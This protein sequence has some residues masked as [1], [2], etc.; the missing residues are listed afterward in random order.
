M[1]DDPTRTDLVQYPPAYPWLVSGNLSR[2]RAEISLSSAERASGPRSNTLDD[3]SDRT[4][5]HRL[6]L[7][8][9]HSGERSRGVVTVTRNRWR[10]AF[11]RRPDDLVRNRRIVV[12]LNRCKA[13]QCLVGPK[14]RSCSRRRLLVTR[15]SALPV[16]VLGGAVVFF[17]RANRRTRFLMAAAVALGTA[18][19][20]RPS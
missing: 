5:S 6:R 4:R 17:G 20:T 15:Q 1:I 14:C 18:L 12:A 16:F 8:H 13:Q 3:L 19:M 9:W 7:A 10:L 2:D 11:V